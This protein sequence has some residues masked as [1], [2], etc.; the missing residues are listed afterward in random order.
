[1]NHIE[2]VNC[3]AQCH[4]R[5]GRPLREEEVP[6]TIPFFKISKNDVGRLCVDGYNYEYHD[7]APR[8]HLWKQYLEQAILP[9]VRNKAGVCGFYPIELHDSYTYLNNG[10]NYK[11]VMTFAK[12]KDDA[13]PILIP[14]PYMIVNWG[15]GL[16]FKDPIPFD[17]K[18]DVVTFYGTTTGHRNPSLN[19]RIQWCTWAMDKPAYDFKITHVAQMETPSIVNAIGQASW[20]KIYLTTRVPREEQVKHK[21]HMVLDGN[22]CRF[23]VWNYKTNCLSL[24]EES[25]E[26]LWYYPMFKNKEHFVEVNKTNVDALRQ[27]YASNPADAMRIARNAQVFSDEVFKPLCHMMYTTTLFETLAENGA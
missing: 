8:M 25:R 14:D 9:N 17:K 27:F 13:G 11:N 4:A 21:F 23:D 26:M 18:D 19:R 7:N 24:K 16:N 20:N 10:K 5:T 12:F 6:Q 1:M 2:A 15:D 3:L 22:T